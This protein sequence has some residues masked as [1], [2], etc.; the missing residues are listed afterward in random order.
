MTS[1]SISYLGSCSGKAKVKKD[2]NEWIDS[3]T[4][5]PIICIGSKNGL[6]THACTTK[7]HVC[8]ELWHLGHHQSPRN[9]SLIFPKFKNRGCLGSPGRSGGFRLRQHHSST[10]WMHSTRE[11]SST[12]STV[13]VH[14]RLFTKLTSSI[15]SQKKNKQTKQNKKKQSSLGQSNKISS[16]SL[17]P[18]TLLWK[19]CEYHFI[20]GL[21]DADCKLG[22]H[23]VHTPCEISVDQGGASFKLWA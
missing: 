3:E 12:H 21:Q 23:R 11:L 18:S 17:L 7:Q 9:F 14:E 16:T 20:S 4:V 8:V 6:S 19:A 1:I 5:S 2:T 22:A 15:T 13:C 10:I